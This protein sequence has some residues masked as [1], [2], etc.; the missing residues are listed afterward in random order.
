MYSLRIQ[1]F[2]EKFTLYIKL[3]RL[4]KPVGILLL[5]WPTLWALWLS[6]DG[7]PSIKIL[8]IFML[9]VVIMR[10]AGCVINDFADRDIDGYVR[11]TNSRPIPNGEISPREAIFI[12]LF[13]SMLAFSLVAFTNTLTL[14]LSFIGVF[15][16]AIYP[17]MKRYTNLP[18]IFLGAAFAWSIPMSFAAVTNKID[19]GLWFLYLAVVIWAV[20][21][22]TFYAMAD[23]A[24]DL[25]IG[26]KS[27]AILFGE[28]DLRITACLQLLVLILLTMTGEYFQRGIWFFMSLVCVIALFIYQQYII[29]NREAANCL[30]AFVNNNYVGLIIFIGL[31]LDYQLS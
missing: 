9:G 26:I 1:S 13:L 14:K 15:L 25:K 6:S 29:R 12:F 23:R 7:I 27:T 10:S 24:D 19:D 22:D 31:A 5:L 28:M 11:R 18:Q 16:A 3:M 4:D 8:F 30:S 21:Y 17:F 2:K 20:T